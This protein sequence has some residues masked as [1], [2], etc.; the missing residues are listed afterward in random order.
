MT[1]PGSSDP[2]LSRPEYIVRRLL[3]A[4][5]VLLGV[6]VVSFVIF[7]V[8]PSRSPAVLSAGHRP[9]AA[10]LATIGH[11]LGLEHPWYVQYLDYLKALVLHFDLGYSHVDDSPV[12]AVIVH[13]LPAT[14]SLVVGAVALTLALGTP[15]GT[16]ATV[17]RGSRVARAGTG[18]LRVVS[19]AP[20]YWVG[21]IVLYLFSTD[22]GRIALLPGVGT[23][24]PL[25]RSPVHWFTS[26][27]MP[28][29]VLGA[30]C[31]AVLG[32]QLASALGD[33]MSTGYVRGA[34]AKGVPEGQVIA[35]HGIRGAITPLH[36]IVATD[37]GVLLG[38]VVLVETVF[39]IPGVGGLL[40]DSVASGDLP[41]VQGIVL[42]GAI[43]VVLAGVIVD[44]I[45]A[46]AAP[47]ARF[48]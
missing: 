34:R 48:S 3:R 1:E 28:W 24:E 18:L 29:F 38:G 8:L 33:V 32:R 39:G 43:V 11:R 22:V 41:M 23:Y 12:R 16:L 45:G 26:L 35:G 20:P 30:S 27:L 6:S 15:L 37:I 9:T 14:I 42:L 7:F 4:V 46:F 25:T 13:R 5:A 31:A 44:L 17:R 47:R 2:R 40:A 10:L 19:S 21:L 36:A